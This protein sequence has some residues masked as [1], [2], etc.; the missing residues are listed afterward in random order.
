M[1]SMKFKVCYDTFS[2]FADVGAVRQ[3]SFC[4]NNLQSG[5]QVINGTSLYRRLGVPL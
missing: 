3:W 5:D 2:D 4:L 1:A